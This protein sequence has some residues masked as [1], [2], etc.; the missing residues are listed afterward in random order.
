MSQS[1]SN[2]GLQPKSD[3]KLPRF[4]T[5]EDVH[6]EL[7]KLLLTIFEAVRTPGDTAQL[8]EASAQIKNQYSKTISAVD[9]L[10]GVDTTRSEQ[11]STIRAT[12]AE[13]RKLREDVLHLREELIEKDRQVSNSISAIV[14]SPDCEIETGPRL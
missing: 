14:S 9:A 2:I 5:A 3:L 11:M 4:T 7:D 6:S 12:D 13:Y 8:K 10:D 1:E